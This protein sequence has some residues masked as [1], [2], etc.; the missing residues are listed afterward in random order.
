METET[1]QN[2]KLIGFN[3]IV[4]NRNEWIKVIF[5]NRIHKSMNIGD[6]LENKNEYCHFF[7]FQL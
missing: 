2:K 5:L 4:S 7:V 1:K 6:I 3:K